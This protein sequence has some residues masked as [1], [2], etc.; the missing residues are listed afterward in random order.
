MAVFGGGE[1]KR[2]EIAT[3]LA[4]GT[5]LS[6]FDEPEVELIFGVSKI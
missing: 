4:R 3:V 1:L 5:K 6:V 2:I